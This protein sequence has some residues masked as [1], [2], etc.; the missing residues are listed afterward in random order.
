MSG[1]S[2]WTALRVLCVHIQADDAVLPRD[3]FLGR[4]PEA[5]EALHDL[6]VDESDPRQDLR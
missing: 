6:D 3:A 4:A 1:Q 2:D 5:V